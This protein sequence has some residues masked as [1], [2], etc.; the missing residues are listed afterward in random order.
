MVPAVAPVNDAPELA[1]TDNSAEKPETWK[2]PPVSSSTR[3][4]E[5]DPPAEADALLTCK[6]SPASAEPGVKPS[7]S[8]ARVASVAR[9]A[10]GRPAF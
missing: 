6:T 7:K 10:G 4:N 8:A 2:V 9:D 1:A 5:P 3:S